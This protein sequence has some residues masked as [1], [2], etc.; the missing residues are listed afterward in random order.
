[1]P[2]EQCEE[3]KYKWGEMGECLYETLEDCQLANQEEFLEEALKPISDKPVDL[4]I[5]F[6]EET[7]NKLHGEG[8][9]VV[10]VEISEEEKINI[11][12]TFDKEESEEEVEVETEESEEIEYGSLTTAMLDDELDDYIDK[13]VDSIKE[14][15]K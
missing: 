12:F 14:L 10:E 6:T 9:V 4:T 13:I 2:C 3:G 1:M 15:H 5:H 11:L 8:E 7:M